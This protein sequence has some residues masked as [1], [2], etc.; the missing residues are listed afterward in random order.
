MTTKARGC[1]AQGMPELPEVEIAA[2][3]LRRWCEG[4][5]LCEAK[6]HDARSLEAW[7]RSTASV[8][9][10]EDGL[11]ETKVA[12]VLR[13]GKNLF[14]NLQGAQEHWLWVHLGM[15]GK[16]VW[17]EGHD[18]GPK[19]TR[20]ELFFPTGRVCFDDP[21][22]FG[23]MLLADA[24]FVQ[25]KRG[26]LGID[27]LDGPDGQGVDA[28]LLEEVLTAGSN[29]AKRRSLK[30]ALMDQKRLAGVGNIHA[31]E[32]LFRARLHPEQVVGSLR[33][34]GW[35]RLA[36]A[37][38]EGLLFAIEDAESGE[39]AYMSEGAHVANPFLVYGRQDKACTEC[40]AA[41]ERKVLQQRSTFFC[42]HCQPSPKAK[43]S[44]KK[45][46][47]K[48][49]SKS[50]RKASKS[51]PKASIPDGKDHAFQPVFAW[52]ARIPEGKVM[53]YGQIA[54]LLERPLSARAVG[55]AMHQLPEGLPWQRV[56]NAQGKC[57]V[58]GQRKLLEAEGI[59]FG[60]GDRFSLKTYRWDPESD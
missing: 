39:I 46:I 24:A 56:V 38:R 27:A 2:R 15:S 11:A 10:F 35:Q 6:V 37:L 1:Y 36:E 8:S 30:A 60:K 50:S 49:A 33:S 54:G 3:S 44:M 25:Q 9:D 55:W 34:E 48:K 5:V 26:S 59:V 14:V 4:S 47:A 7:N 17:R 51:S 42:P 19:H 53:T 32:A 12:G 41:I 22:L 23:G 20:I 18:A 45:N 31:C 43:R 16:L 29:A 57:S 13:H 28:T 21:R 58:P 52:V 40:G